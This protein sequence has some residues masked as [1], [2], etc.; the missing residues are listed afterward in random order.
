[1]G[2]GAGVMSPGI[3][4]RPEGG[5]DRARG[6]RERKF[7]YIVYCTCT[8]QFSLVCCCNAE[9]YM[10]WWGGHLDASICTKLEMQNRSTAHLGEG[11]PSWG[12]KREKERQ[13]TPN[14]PAD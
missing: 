5:V 4:E 13:H 3:G 14:P 1:M 12:R 6:H 8:I 11:T 2:A 10:T 7:Q 9:Q